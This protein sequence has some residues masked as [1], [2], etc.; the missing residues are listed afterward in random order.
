MEMMGYMGVQ[1]IQCQVC[2]H[3][4][5]SNIVLSCHTVWANTNP[6]HATH[7]VSSLQRADLSLM[8]TK[9][10]GK[11]NTWLLAKDTHF[12]TPEMKQFTHEGQF[13]VVTC[14]Y[15]A[16]QRWQLTHN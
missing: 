8:V 13:C 15:T 10:R 2:T 4:Y 5:I 6:V 3:S 14:N 11:A 7:M 12:F 1:H 16:H 9:G